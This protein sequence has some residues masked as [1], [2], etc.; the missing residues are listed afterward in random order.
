MGNKYYD[1]YCAIFERENGKI[2]IVQEV[3]GIIGKEFPQ[4]STCWEY[5]TPSGPRQKSYMW[6]GDIHGTRRRSCILPGVLIDEGPGEAYDLHAKN[7][8]SPDAVLRSSQE[9]GGQKRHALCFPPFPRRG[10]DERRDIDHCRAADARR[11]RA[12][13]RVNGKATYLFN[14]GSKWFVE[15]RG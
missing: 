2:H 6:S 4:K 10:A 12:V 3:E 1:D 9:S 7:K 14:E 13:S 8:A 15:A 5:A 11:G